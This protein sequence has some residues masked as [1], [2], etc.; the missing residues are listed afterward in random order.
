[1]LQAGKAQ[2]SKMYLNVLKAHAALHEGLLAVVLVKKM[3]AL[4]LQTGRTTYSHVVHAFCKA[5]ALQVCKDGHKF[6]CNGH[7][8]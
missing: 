3:R 8:H 4:G 7:I 1:M 2:A 5:G 6:A